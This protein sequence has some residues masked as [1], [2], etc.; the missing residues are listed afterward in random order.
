[1][2]MPVKD[3][4]STEVADLIKGKKLALVVNLQ[5]MQGEKAEAVMQILRP[6]FGNIDTIV[7]TLK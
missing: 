4:L 2:L 6:I 7:Y 5:A 1:M 3:P